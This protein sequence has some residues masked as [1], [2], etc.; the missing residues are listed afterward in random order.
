[1]LNAANEVAV[2][3]FLDERI[4]FTDIAATIAAALD[5]HTATDVSTPETV[6]DLD[7]AVR[8]K[9]RQSI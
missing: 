2:E 9:I 1:V 6:L 4:G 3:A 7:R 8:D 5:R